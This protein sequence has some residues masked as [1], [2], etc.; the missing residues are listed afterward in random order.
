[1]TA[2]V[3]DQQTPAEAYAEWWFLFTHPGA[4][5]VPGSLRLVAPDRFVVRAD[6][7]IEMLVIEGIVEV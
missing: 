5:I 3:H 1:M 7:S 6:A 4:R 2:P